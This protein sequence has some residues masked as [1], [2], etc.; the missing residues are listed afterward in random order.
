MRPLTIQ[1][2]AIAWRVLPLLLGGASLTGCIAL[3][4]VPIIASTGAIAYQGVAGERTREAIAEGN[5]FAPDTVELAPVAPVTFPPPAP[6]PAPS[7]LLVPGSAYAELA[8]YADE[9]RGQGTSALLAD[10]T[11]LTPQRA[12]CEARPPAVLFDIDPAGGVAA[13][14]NP[15]LIDPAFATLV[16]DL[17]AAGIAIAWM[18]NREPAEAAALRTVLRDLGLDE[19][20]RDPLFV[21]RFPGE[22]KQSRRRALLETHCLLAIGGDARA[23]FDDVY[24]YLRNPDDAAPLEAMIGYGWFI[25]PNPI[26]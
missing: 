3:A 22:D 20:G 2:R 12:A 4:A 21:Q 1:W 9:V 18:T 24:L 7:S 6:A 13:I 23:D 25:L 16:A 11:Q 26:N 10:P 19:A 5:D 14:E 15:R 8:S 17:R